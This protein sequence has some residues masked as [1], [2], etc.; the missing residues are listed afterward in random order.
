MSVASQ[1]AVS[2]RNHCRLHF[3]AILLGK[4]MGT[5]NCKAKTECHPRDDLSQQCLIHCEFN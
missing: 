2:H 3:D 4:R 1:N 5:K